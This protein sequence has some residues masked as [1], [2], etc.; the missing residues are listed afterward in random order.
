MDFQL[1]R[2]MAPPP[3]TMFRDHRH[4]LF[5]GANMSATVFHISNSSCSLLVYRKVIDF[6]VLPYY[7]SNLLII[8]RIISSV[9]LDFYVDSHVVCKCSFIFS[10]PTCVSFLFS[11]FFFSS[12]TVLARIFTMMVM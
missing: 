12:V 5:G 4:F 8:S 11:F 10:F 2:R 9:V 6:F 7:S 3:P 1:C